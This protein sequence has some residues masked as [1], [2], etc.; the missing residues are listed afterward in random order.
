MSKASLLIICISLKQSVARRNNITDEI[1][2]LEQLCPELSIDFKFFD[3]IYGK[4]LAPEYLSFINIA[5]EQAGLCQRPLVTGEIG[6]L[7][8]HLFVWQRLINGDYDQ[9]QRVIIIEDDVYLNKNRLNEKLLDIQNSKEDFIFLGGHALKSRTRIHG[10]ASDNQLYFNM[11]GPSYL[12]STACAYSL[13]KAAATDFLY[14]LIAKP[15]FV[16]D[17]QYLLKDRFKV[18]HYFCF[19]QGGEEDSTIGSNRVDVKPSTTIDRLKKNLPKIMQD[20]VARL[21][22]LMV[23]KRCTSLSQFFKQAGEDGYRI[24][25]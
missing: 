5:R 18:M 20:L 25:Q 7:L 15:T 12:Y 1:Q 17:W 2:Q 19:E 4:D 23:F 14:K 22:L 3:G 6:C 16:D 8:S 10:Y 9:Y 11:L 24:D 13:N 21:K